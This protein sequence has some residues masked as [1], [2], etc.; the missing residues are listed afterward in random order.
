MYLCKYVCIYACMMYA[1]ICVYTR[2]ST[3]M[4]DA[5][6]YIC[7]HIHMYDIY[8]FNFKYT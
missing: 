6:M 8:Q 2:V 7:I 1:R 3:C 5:C 4:Y